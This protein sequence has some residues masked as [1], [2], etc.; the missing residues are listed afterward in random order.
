MYRRKRNVP[1]LLLENRGNRGWFAFRRPKG[2]LPKR[3]NKNKNLD[4]WV[5]LSF[6]P[7]VCSNCET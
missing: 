5:S 7:F 3:R 6:V 2:E 4:L 1:G